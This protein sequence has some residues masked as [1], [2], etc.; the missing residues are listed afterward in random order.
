MVHQ[1]V[2][3]KFEL[4]NL[5]NFSYISGALKSDEINI[6]EKRSY[7]EE[8]FTL[9]NTITSPDVFDNKLLGIR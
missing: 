6:Y 2:S 5:D 7:D 8:S 1:F 4:I 9:T 3:F